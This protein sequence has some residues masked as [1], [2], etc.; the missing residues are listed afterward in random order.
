MDKLLGMLKQNIASGVDKPCISGNIL[1]DPEAKLNDSKEN[2][3]EAFLQQ[4]D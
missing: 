4:R 2:R 3:L 1:K